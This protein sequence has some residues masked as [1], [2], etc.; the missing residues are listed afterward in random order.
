M[1]LTHPEYRALAAVSVGNLPQIALPP[2]IWEV[3]LVEQRDGENDG[4]ARAR[5]SAVERWHEEG[6]RVSVW[7]P[8]E[9]FKDA[10]DFWRDLQR[11]DERGDG[12]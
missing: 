9:G 6:R 3:M 12:G 5:R 7:R 11:R 10:N 4:V 1:A 8:P 2:G